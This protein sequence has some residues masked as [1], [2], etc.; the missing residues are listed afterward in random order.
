MSAILT[1]TASWADKAVIE[2]G[3]YPATVK[4]A[5]NR[6]QYYAAHFPVVEIDSTYYALPA[7]RNAQLWAERTPPDF[8]FDVKAFRLF[9][10]H[11]LHPKVLPKD[12]RE[13]LGPVAKAN[14]YPRDIPDEITRELWNRFRL[15]L[16]PLKL[17]GKLGAILF[18]FAPW[19]VYGKANLNHIQ[20]C[21]EMLEDHRLAVEFRNKSWLDEKHRD[22]VLAFE[23]EYELVHVIV[24][25]P[26]G[27]SSSVPAVWEVTCP[28]L[29]I[30]R[31]HGRN[32]STWEAKGLRTS[33]ER[34]NYLY[35]DAELGELA[36]QVGE[37]GAAA[38]C[39]HTLF[40][41]CHDD[42]AQRNAIAFRRLLESLRRDT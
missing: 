10:G 26:Q 15:A 29:A 34:F 17:A 9:T 1:G 23:R 41:N 25:E 8:V 4:S 32:R 7:E 35:S 30:V 31:F 13:A 33:A 19:F 24:D 27:F 28:D 22:R 12:I 2:S 18:Q 21:R 37:L 36:G 6:L 39:V 3:W 40:N 42:K 11:H 5:E 20:N 14:L 38:D 16:E